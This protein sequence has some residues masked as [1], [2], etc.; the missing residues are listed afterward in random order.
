MTHSLNRP[1]AV[2]VYGTLRPGHGNHDWTVGDLP[3]TATPARL[4]GFRLVGA[5]HPFPFALPAPGG[6]VIGEVLS[7]DIGDWPTALHMM[8]RLEGYPVLYDRVGV[9]VAALADGRRLRAWL[10]T[11]ADPDRHASLAE[12]PGGDWHNIHPPPRVT[13]VR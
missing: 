12:V 8:D 7:F 4:E 10:Y 1:A 2:F 6:Q 5:D 3:H 11:P 13:A 9:E